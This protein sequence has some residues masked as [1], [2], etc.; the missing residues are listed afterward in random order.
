MGK[1]IY[2]VRH[3]E[4]DY[5]KLRMLQGRG[6]DA[7]LNDLGKKQAEALAVYFRN[8][9]LDAIFSS[10]MCRAISTAEYIAHHHKG[11]ISAFEDLEE[12]DY[13]AYEGIEYIEVAEELDMI[14]NRWMN[15]E[16]DLVITGGESP[17]MVLN[18]AERRIIS[19]LES[20]VEDDQ[21]ILF[22]VHGRLIRILLSHWL[23]GSL[24]HM[25]TIGTHNC[26]INHLTWQ[27]NRMQPVVLNETGHLS[28]L[29]QEV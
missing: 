3:G 2:I 4:T 29:T 8:H 19:L 24:K 5:N 10:T 25:H 14:K 17:E 6:I 16:T 27:N 21:T 11:K 20:S 15:G 13:G 22:V 7:P 28:H 1:N 9:R 12:M 26:S 23:K 18:R